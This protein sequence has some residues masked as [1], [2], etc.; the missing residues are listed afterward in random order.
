MLYE[1]VPHH[2]V[3]KHEKVSQLLCTGLVADTQQIHRFLVLPRQ[4]PK[5]PMRQDTFTEP[6][7]SSLVLQLSR[8]VHCGPVI[9]LVAEF[10][11][12]HGNATPNVLPLSTRGHILMNLAQKQKQCWGPVTC[13]FRRPATCLGS[14]S[15]PQAAGSR[16]G[17]RSIKIIEACRADCTRMACLSGRLKHSAEAF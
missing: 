10:M 6:A 5:P 16:R 3:T 15:R 1:Q 11:E 12:I 13:R 8:V 4:Q 9:L 7:A 17:Q 14:S 2:I